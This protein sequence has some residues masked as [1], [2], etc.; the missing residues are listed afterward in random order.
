MKVT[1][2]LKVEPDAAA[3]EEKPDEVKVEANARC[4]QRYVDERR[5]TGNAGRKAQN[6][7]RDKVSADN[8]GRRIKSLFAPTRLLQINA[9]HTPRT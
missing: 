5:T 2:K 6:N 1:V 4:S 7:A 8:A 3:H 9:P